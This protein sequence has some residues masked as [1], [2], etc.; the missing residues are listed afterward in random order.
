M[1]DYLDMHG[2]GKEETSRIAW[3]LRTGL[4][5]RFYDVGTLS[6]DD[7]LG[8]LR[9]PLTP[10]DDSTI[11]DDSASLIAREEGEQ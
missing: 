9:G 3:P 4:V 7:A 6:L 10:G 2:F 5:Q 8:L 1:S 11:V